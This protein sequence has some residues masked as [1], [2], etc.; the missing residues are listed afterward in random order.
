MTNKYV[1]ILSPPFSGST[2]LVKLLMTSEEVSVNNIENNKEGQ[3]LDGVKQWMRKGTWD[4]N[5]QMPWDEI[6][7]VW[8]K[9]WNLDLPILLEK[10]PPNIIR[11]QAIEKAFDSSYFICTN[12][13]PYAFCEGKLRRD[14][15]LGKDTSGKL[16]AR[17]W[18]KCAKHQ[19]NNIENLQNTL[20]FSYEQFS[21]KPLNVS[22]KI[23]QFLP[24]I[25]RLKAKKNFNVRNVL[26]N[27]KMGIQNL[28]KEKI[29]RLSK[30][31]KI[32]ISIELSKHPELMSFFSYKI[33]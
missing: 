4:E 3:F 27:P 25:S 16:A 26:N 12:R 19:K 21:N 11:A 29:D 10:S 7:K 15:E 23:Q 17:F 22:R 30:D 13:N 32:Q 5:T 6:K 2:L 14:R 28:N 18:I 24:E 33:I 31:E 1:F 20:Y 9:H 8:D